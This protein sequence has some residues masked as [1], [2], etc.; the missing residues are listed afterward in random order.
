MER[1]TPLK[2]RNLFFTSRLT[3]ENTYQPGAGIGAKSTSVKRALQR[4]AAKK[5]DGSSYAVLCTAGS[6][7]TTSSSSSSSSS[8]GQLSNPS[9]FLL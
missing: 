3:I 2:R 7:T 4:R 5:K 8:G 6:Q 1:V 9:M